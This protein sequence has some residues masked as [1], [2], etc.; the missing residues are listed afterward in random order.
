[1][2]AAAVAVTTGCAPQTTPPV[3]EQVQKYYDENNTLKPVEYK[4]LP[5]VAFFGD[6]YTSGVGA[7]QGNKRWT[8]LLAQ[9]L[10][11]TEANMGMGGT[12]YLTTAGKEGCGKDTCPNYAGMIGAAV[13]AKPSV[14]VVSGGR[15]DLSQ[16]PTDVAAAVRDFFTALRSELPEAKIIVTS[17]VWDAT[18]PP[19]R[20]DELARVVEGEAKA[21]KATYLDV[22]EPL[23]GHTNL[24]TSDKVHPN[25]AGHQ[26]LSIAVEGALARAAAAIG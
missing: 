3:S 11:W 12:G 5:T 1:M 26:A 20:L 19:A 18:A 4:E 14:V 7:S 21:A 23:V 8:T 24:I 10:R 6:S 25:D 15:N 22:G 13:K 9:K 17:P 2:L 16:N